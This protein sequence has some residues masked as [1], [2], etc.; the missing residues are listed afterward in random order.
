[1]N[2][3]P[4]KPLPLK[5]YAC[6][7]LLMALAGLLRFWGLERTGP[8]FVDQGDYMLEARWFHEVALNLADALPDWVREPPQD[9]AA[10]AKQLFSRSEGHPMIMGRPL[11]VLL[12]ALPMF[13]VGYK[14]WLGNAVS[15][16]FGVLSVALVYLLYRK[17]YGGRGAL[18]AAGLLAVLGIHVHYSRNFFPETD[19]TFFLLLSLLFYAASREHAPGA[20]NTRRLL[21]SGICWGLAIACNDRWITALLALWLMEAHL[22]LWERRVTLGQALRR[23][24]VL[25]LAV[26]APLVAIELPYLA[27]RVAAGAAGKAMPFPG[28]FEILAKHFLIAQAMAAARF[29]PSLPMSGFR[30]E[31]LAILPDISIRYNGFLFTSLLAAGLIV[32]AARRRFPDLLLLACF[33]VPVIHLHLQIYHCMRHYSITFP[34]MAI[35]SARALVELGSGLPPRRS[36]GDDAGVPPARNPFWAILFLMALTSGTLASLSASRFDFGYPEASRRIAQT[37]G[38]VLASNE[39]VFQS[40][41][42]SSACRAVP[43]SREEL[44]GAWQEGYRH[45]AVDFLPV[46][47]RHLQEI[48]IQHEDD[49]R[50]LDLVG[51]MTGSNDPAASIPNPGSVS[52]DTTFEVLFQYRDAFAVAEKVRRVGADS[53][54]IYEIPDP[55]R[56]PEPTP[57]KPR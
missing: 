50:R 33:F 20:R 38:K 51:R 46:V 57:S 5:T 42:G 45:L 27:L 17:L 26:M 31:D 23:W 35:L 41:L 2:H 28:Y 24:A 21:A 36:G 40:Y 32:A 54:R 44:A 25:N 9:P 3:H 30:F 14:A 13:F 49:F 11:H 4:R 29:I 34:L 10:Q 55:A 7:L 15:A 19:S 1:M 56:W 12:A 52:R 39:R 6:L 16:F 47:W 22:W 18:V 43:V 37:G 53:I 48:G 8:Y